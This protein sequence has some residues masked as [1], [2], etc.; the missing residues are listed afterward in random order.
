M[1]LILDPATN[2][3]GYAIFNAPY[4]LNNYGLINL[5]KISKEDQTKKRFELI[6]QIKELV[7]KFE[8]NLITTEGVYFHSNASTHEKLSK[9]QGSIQDFSYSNNIICF[10]WSNAGE[11]RSK[12]GIKAKKREDYKRET[13]E[14]VLAHYDV[15]DNL[16]E[17]ECDA[18]AMGDAYFVMIENLEI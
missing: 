9:V 12:I 13:K 6:K 16:S 11:W 1:F 3:T 2:I 10:S 18:I 15:P 14:Y 7:L 4:K 17:D 5:S 8:I